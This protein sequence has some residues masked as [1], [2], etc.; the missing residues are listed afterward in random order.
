MKT[1]VAIWAAV[2][3]KPQAAEDKTSLSDQENLGCQYAERIGGEVV[4]IYKVPGHT[5]DV[6]F[7]DEAANAMPAYRELREDAEAGAFDDLWVLD[8]DR[9]GRDPA[10][11]HQVASLVQ[12][13]GQRLWVEDGQYYVSEESSAGG[14]MFAF[15][16]QRGGEMQKKRVARHDSGMR[17]RVKR[18]LPP[19]NWPHGYRGIR[20][21]TGKTV[22][23]EFVPGEIEAVRFVTDLFLQG[24]GYFSIIR[25]LDA[26]PW[27]PR[28]S[29]HWAFTTVRGMLVNE[30]YAGFVSYG[31][32]HNPEPSDKFPTLWDSETYKAILREHQQRSRGGSAPASPVSGCVICARCGRSMS[33]LLRR[34]KRYF[35]CTQHAAYGHIRPC[36]HN[37]IRESVIIEFLEFAISKELQR[38]GGVEAALEHIGPGRATIEQEIVSIRTHIETIEEKQY[39]LAIL[40]EDGAIDIEAA[41]RRTSE[42]AEQLAAADR[43]LRQSQ[44]KLTV[45][46][47]PTEMRQRFEQIAEL[48]DLRSKPL[49]VV[50]NLLLRAGVKVYVENREIVRIVFGVLS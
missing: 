24:K 21:E 45:L 15:Q 19:N 33:S 23:G 34:G 27:R 18:G 36:H 38:P 14:Y 9:L 8:P 1:R 10:L 25:E 37:L 44:E 6:T 20:D 41:R 5:R 31:E 2:S 42:L 17:G 48:V 47:D 16:S 35:R 49:E 22:G 4:K 50:R 43:L 40:A 13:S 28:Y 39:R 26:S 46:P 32:V 30:I 7:W 12:K 11:S 29:D 3:S